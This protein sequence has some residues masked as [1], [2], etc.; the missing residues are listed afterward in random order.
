MFAL[1]AAASGR[2]A[3]ADRWLDWLYAHRT[4]LGSLPEKVRADG[5]PLSV[6]TLAWTSGIVTLSLVALEDGLPTPADPCPAKK[7]NQVLCR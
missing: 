4:S 6:A 3:E 7:G 5:Q 2:E 1:Q